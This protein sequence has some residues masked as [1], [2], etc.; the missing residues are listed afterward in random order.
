[1][2]DIY[3]EVTDNIIAAIEANPGKVVMP[4]QRGGV[5]TIPENAL[6]GNWYNGINILNLWVMTEIRGYSNSLW[7]TFKQWKTKGA[8]VR[9][10]EKAS[11]VI[12]YKE[13]EIK[14]DEE[15][16]GKRRIIR[17]SSVFNIDQVDGFEVPAVDG[18]PIDRIAEAD[19][20]VTAIISFQNPK[21]YTNPNAKCPV[22]G[23]S[24]FFYQSEHGGRVFFDDLGWPWPKHPCTDT[25]G[26]RSDTAIIAPSNVG[27]Q[28]SSGW[29]ANY[30]IFNLLSLKKEDGRAHFVFRENSNGL[31]SAI[32]R[33]FKNTDQ[34][35]SF[36]LKKLE[37]AGVLD[38]DFYEAPN[39][40]IEK[41]ELT[42]EKPILHFIFGRKKK[43]QR[44]KMRR[45][46]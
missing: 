2:R 38:S 19:S 24:V 39:F 36:S 3:Q 27:K 7:G 8:Q 20:F 11:L 5:H 40:L 41:K 45:S 26:A 9:K 18:D 44:I 17:A 31:Y 10:G 33:L 43:I 4:W 6:T 23:E 12:F 28:S 42:S 46:P 15:G 1:M 25:V 29:V 34:N 16:D 30:L 14:N 35:L 21:S 13:I 22:C 37:T 32:I